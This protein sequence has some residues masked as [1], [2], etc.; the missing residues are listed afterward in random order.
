M[1]QQG[2]LAGFKVVDVSSA[3]SGPLTSALLADHGADVVLIEPVGRY[4]PVRMTGPTV[5]DVSGAWV[6]MNR[7]K[8][9]M[10]VNVRD[11]RGL[12]VVARLAAAADVF[13]QNF[14]PG[15]AE[16]L[17]L[18]YDALS[19][20]NRELVYLSISGFGTDGP[21]A[22][23]PVY[24][25]VV[26]AISGL[27]AVQGGTLVKTL[28]PDKVTAMTAAHAVMAALL[29][30]ARGGSGQHIELN[31]L[32]STVAFLWPDA[33]WNEAVP[34]QPPVPNYTDWYEPYD[35]VD[36]RITAVW[37]TQDQYRRGVLAL[38]RPDLVDD[39]RFATRVDRVRN[40][41]VMRQ[42][43][44][45]AL[46]PYTTADALALLREADVPS[47]RVNDRASA[48]HDPQLIHNQVLVEGD[49]PRLG[50][51]RVARP[52]ARM[53]ATPPSLRS[54]APGYGEHTD[55]VLGELGLGEEEIAAL[56][57]DAVVA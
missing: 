1:G 54:P 14:R 37:T 35:T 53:S 57:A 28:I 39:P 18:G 56:R 15:V 30:R 51:T 22:D 13:V 50:R 12:D 55:E 33:M 34:D 41:L 20:A 40:A 4:D 52:P 2:A 42:E 31:M 9:A 43:F 7:N 5:G 10:A 27:A 16:R 11:P 17:G 47:A 36:G 46:E 23:Q 38:G 8:R 26:Q 19:A 24:D 6:A 45:K 25:P 3:V 32:D 49:D 29:A 48:L 44:A 21:Y